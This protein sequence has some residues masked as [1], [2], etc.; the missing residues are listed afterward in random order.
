M[1]AHLL[2]H[3]ANGQRVPDAALDRL[4]TER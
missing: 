1:V 2:Q 3:R 4:K